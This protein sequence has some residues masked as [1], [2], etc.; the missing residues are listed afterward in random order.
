MWASAGQREKG[1]E[2]RRGQKAADPSVRGRV[3]PKA[4]VVSK[5]HHQAK[6]NH[7]PDCGTSLR[8]FQV[9][10]A[11]QSVLSDHNGIKLETSNRK[12]N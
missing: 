11:L 3:S 8:A 10:E 5:T 2:T 9:I 1:A 6:Q 4:H 12:D 7:V